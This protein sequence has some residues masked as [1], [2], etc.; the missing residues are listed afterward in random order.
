[1]NGVAWLPRVGITAD[2]SALAAAAYRGLTE[3]RV[4][5]RLSLPTL[6]EL[7][8][9]DPRGPQDTAARLAPGTPLV[10]RAGEQAVPLF[11]GEVTAVTWVYG[12]SGQRELRVRGYDLLH[13]LRK[14]Q[15]LKAHVNVTVAE[16][17]SGCLLYTSPSPRDR[18]RSRM[19][20]SA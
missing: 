3:V 8:F 14:R 9:A 12:P 6:C 11:T 1:M 2:G 18:T 10:V 4:Q 17:A 20:S 13:R 15:P 7:V 19:P 5:Q 16:L